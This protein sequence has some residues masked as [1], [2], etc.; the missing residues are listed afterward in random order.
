VVV[1]PGRVSTSHFG[2][3]GWSAGV[4]GVFDG[5]QDLYGVGGYGEGWGNNIKHTQTVSGEEEGR[6]RGGVRCSVALTGKRAHEGK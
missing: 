2:T 5:S 4:G 1:A 6:R 3:R